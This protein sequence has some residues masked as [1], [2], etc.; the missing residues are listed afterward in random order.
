MKA[1][2]FISIIFLIACSNKKE[3]EAA[4]EMKGEEV[5]D[6]STVKKDT[7]GYSTLS[8][9]DGFEK[10]TIDSKL[11]FEEKVDLW[12][13]KYNLIYSEVDGNKMIVPERYGN[14]FF[15]K[16]FLKKKNPIKN[17]KNEEIFPEVQFYFFQFKDSSECRNVVNNWLQCYGTECLSVEWMKETDAKNSIPSL[18]IITKNEIIFMQTPTDFDKLDW[19]NI[20]R[21][22]EQAFT[23]KSNYVTIEILKKDKKLL[24]NSY[25]K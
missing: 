24:W 14:E 3:Q 12:V 11:P 21:D 19:L 15:K 9:Y 23:Q 13:E 22:L 2:F 16:A 7:I 20:K 1:I 5:N 4:E 18:A 8:D 6:T 25:W 10:M 17:K